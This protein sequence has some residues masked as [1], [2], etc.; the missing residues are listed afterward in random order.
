MKVQ[1]CIESLC[2]LYLLYHWSLGNQTRCADLLLLITKP[3]TTK[4]PHTDSSPLTY[5]VTS[6]RLTST[7]WGCC[8]LCFWLVLLSNPILSLVWWVHG[9]VLWWSK[10][11]QWTLHRA[12][13]CREMNA[14]WTR[15]AVWEL[16]EVPALS[17]GQ[18]SKPKN[19]V[20]SLLDSHFF[21]FTVSPGEWSLKND[22]KCGVKSS[23]VFGWIWTK[24]SDVIDSLLASGIPAVASSMVCWSTS[25]AEFRPK[26]S[27][28]NG[29]SLHELRVLWWISTRDQVL[30]ADIQSEDQSCWRQ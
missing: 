17:L 19:S 30:A 5:T 21:S 20:S 14:S 18:V 24:A 29:T 15:F 2:I 9:V 25:A 6:C 13:P 12:V 11:C 23:V 1:N 26:I 16:H 4:W 7:W 27:L 28:C 8:R 10:S 22:D 3:S